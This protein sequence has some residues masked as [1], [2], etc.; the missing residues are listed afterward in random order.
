MALKTQ[1]S[2]D[3]R[4]LIN[5]DIVP[6][7]KF[8]ELSKKL[9]WYKENYE[10]S[11]ATDGRPIWVDFFTTV[12]EIMTGYQSQLTRQQR[13]KLEREEGKFYKKAETNR[14]QNLSNNKKI[15]NL[16]YLIARAGR[17]SSIN[18]FPAGFYGKDGMINF[19]DRGNVSEEQ[20][21]SVKTD[22]G[23]EFTKAQILSAITE[24]K[25]SLLDDVPSI[26]KEWEGKVKNFTNDKKY[27]LFQIIGKEGIDSIMDEVVNVKV[28]VSSEVQSVNEMVNFNGKNNPWIFMHFLF[29]YLDIRN[30][31]QNDEIFKIL[32]EKGKYINLKNFIGYKDGESEHPEILPFLPTA[33]ALIAN[34]IKDY[35]WENA[36]DDDENKLLEKLKIAFISLGSQTSSSQQKVKDFYDK[37]VPPN[38]NLSDFHNDVKKVA[39]VLEKMV[40]DDSMNN[41]MDL[42]N[43]LKNAVEHVSY[44]DNQSDEK[45]AHAK[46]FIKSRFSDLI[47]KDS[48]KLIYAIALGSH[49]PKF[50]LE[51][52]SYSNIESFLSNIEYELKNG[53][54]V[55]PYKTEFIDYTITNDELEDMFKSQAG[56]WDGKL[57]LLFPII[58]RVVLKV[59]ENIGTDTNIEHKQR[60]L[61][62]IKESTGALKEAWWL[63]SNTSGN[64]VQVGMVDGK[65][66]VHTSWQ[67]LEDKDNQ[68]EVGCVEESSSNSGG[69]R[70]A[71]PNKL[72]SYQ[73]KLDNV[74]DWYSGGKISKT[75]YKQSMRTLQD[76]IEHIEEIL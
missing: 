58:K 63:E 40:V 54:E 35:D 12:R 69:K 36:T 65:L 38:L 64:F 10:K 31:F 71:K 55:V 53:I 75:Q 34:S 44:S 57:K 46:S 67:H 25:E 41:V 5:A 9:I 50:T 13:R 70:I 27:T 29:Q 19:L 48:I 15:D 68:W 66:S 4:F 2:G 33:I 1:S 61:A 7:D 51:D 56:S 22:G 17:C 28:M 16:R 60:E 72:K 39:D 49:N 18:F 11:K 30:E 42:Y 73:R 24:I 59:R 74:N 20:S 21:E 43:N 6:Y 45:K 3:G 37:F 47:K 62:F 32:S 52:T 14:M 8:D 26:I 76:I 23:K